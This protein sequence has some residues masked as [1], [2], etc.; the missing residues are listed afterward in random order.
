MT[1]WDYKV[2]NL[3]LTRKATLLGRLQPGSLPDEDPMVKEMR[4]LGALGW[5][6]VSVYNEPP[7]LGV[8]LFF[9]RAR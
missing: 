3:T 1:V 2:V 8:T 5:E 4:D 7:Y 6:L 9:K